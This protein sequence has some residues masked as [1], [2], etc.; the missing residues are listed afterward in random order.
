[1]IYLKAAIITA[2][3][4]AALLAITTLI[5]ILW[6][7]MVVVALFVGIVFILKVNKPVD[8]SDKGL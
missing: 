6:P 1:M 2:L 4:V 8:K 5:A 7:I 3:V